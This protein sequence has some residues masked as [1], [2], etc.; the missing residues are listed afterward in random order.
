MVLQSRVRISKAVVLAVVAAIAASGETL[1]DD[2]P[3]WLGPTRDGVY[4]ES[5]IVEEIPE[6]GLPVK[7][8]AEVAGGY[9]GP[10]VADGRVY[11]FDYEKRSGEAFNDP[12][13][14]ATLDGEERLTAF[15]AES[16]EQLWRH[17][18]ACPYG[19]SYPAGPRCTPTVDGDRVYI[20]G[21]EGDLRCL[22]GETGELV[23][24]RSFQEDFAAEV[25]IW[26]FASHPL[27]DGD[28]LVCMVGG[29][30]QGVVAFDKMTG[31]V[32]WKALDANAGY[33]PPSIIE[34]GGTRQLIVFHPQ[35]V[36]S[37]NPEDG[38][39][40]WDV[41]IAPSYEMSIA[42]PMVEGN[43]L[44]ASGIGEAAVM[45]ELAQERPAAKEL[46]RGQGRRHAL[47]AS[48]CTPILAGGVIYGADC[49]KGTFVAANAAD[50]ERLWETFEPIRPD[51]ERRVNHGTAFLTRLGDSHRYLIF[52]EIGDLIV[53]TL[54]P[55][56]YEEH[57]RF[58]VLEP[59]SEAFGRSVVW[60]HPAYAGRTAFARNDEEVVAV[61]LAE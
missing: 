6:D 27:V 26:G 44:Y 7:W 24:S 14:R 50:G 3:G 35:A 28:R 39:P 20:L 2:W 52:S 45:V 41:P 19:I 31:E 4:R 59:T 37:L 8:R 47:Y 36:M 58:H 60:S 16:G 17:E 51:E 38:S 13:T 5:G 53:A 33:A 55:D 54:T 21:S 11:V 29:T 9:A 30:G 23:W 22:R 10:A 15:D 25:P 49:G 61:D 46:W 48:N 56:G 40:Y 18:Y 32:V 43:R 57:G 12:G 42:R 1:A 34:A